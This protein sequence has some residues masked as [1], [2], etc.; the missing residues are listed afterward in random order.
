MCPYWSPDGQVIAFASDAGGEFDNFTVPVGGGEPRRL[1]S[2]PGIDICP[3][4][5]WDGKWIYFA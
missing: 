3:T 5:S 4:F 2:H 1:T